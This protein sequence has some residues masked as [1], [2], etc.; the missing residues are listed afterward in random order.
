MYMYMCICSG[1]GQGDASLAPDLPMQ[2][3]PPDIAPTVIR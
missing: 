2:Q 3:P 1:S